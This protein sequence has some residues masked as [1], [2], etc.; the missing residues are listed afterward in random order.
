MPT[1]RYLMTPQVSTA[2]VTEDGLGRKRATGSSELKGT[3]A[4]PLLLG[5]ALAVEFDI[6][7]QAVAMAVASATQAAAQSVES[8]NWPASACMEVGDIDADVAAQ[9]DDE[10]WANPD[11]FIM[12]IASNQPRLWDH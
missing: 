5:A 1:A 4:Y 12:D 6:Y 9:G 3:Q 11:W 8:Y 7:T 10:L 2:V